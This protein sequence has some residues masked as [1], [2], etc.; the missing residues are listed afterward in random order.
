M[1]NIFSRSIVGN[2]IYEFDWKQKQDLDR[3]RPSRHLDSETNRQTVRETI[4]EPLCCAEQVVT[5]IGIPS[6][7]QT[8]SGRGSSL[9]DSNRLKQRARPI[10]C[11]LSNRSYV[12]LGEDEDKIEE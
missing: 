3:R 8:R 6:V 11:W 10:L 5:L 9:E 7:K 4:T 2:N 12:R 1:V